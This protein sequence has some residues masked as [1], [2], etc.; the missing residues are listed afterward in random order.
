MLASI[1]LSLLAGIAVGALLLILGLRGKRINDHPTCR[2]CGFDLENV[3]PACITCP[4]C[5]SGL[6]RPKAVRPGQRR[7]RPVFIAAGLLLII[8]AIL[9]IG[10]AGFAAITGQD[11]NQYKPLGLLLW[12]AR[13]ADAKNGK[14]IAADLLTRM[15]SGKLTPAQEDRIT[16]L[17]LARQ[18]DPTVPWDDAW[19]DLIDRAKLDGRLSA[20]QQQ[21]FL[22]NLVVPRLKVRPHV[23]TGD[24]IPIGVES[25]IRGSPSMQNIVMIWL[26]D[27]RLNG[28][29]ISGSVPETQGA[30]PFMSW[31][32]A[33]SMP[34]TQIYAGGSKTRGFFSSSREPVVV[35]FTQPEDVNP[36]HSEVQIDLLVQAVPW[37]MN[38]PSSFMNTKPRATDPK[39]RLWKLR[40]PV[41]LVSNDVGAI[42]RVPSSNELS[43]KLAAHLRPNNVMV[44]GQRSDWMDG[45]MLT[46]T[47]Q[48]ADLPVPV[49]F[50]VFGRQGTHLEPLGSFTSGVGGSDNGFFG[51]QS[52]EGMRTL[53][54]NPRGIKGSNMD[55]VLKPRP[56]LAARTLDMTKVYDGEIVIE[57]V[58]IRTIGQAG[59][60]TSTTSTTVTTDSSD[61]AAKEDQP[62]T[63]D[64]PA[65]K[66]QAKS[67]SWLSKWVFFWN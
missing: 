44:Y 48:V 27:S 13:H 1:L 12:E 43:E 28:K 7:R 62:K 19:G 5:G 49:A 60:V 52:E 65:K 6:N 34:L 16:D 23:A 38:G 66:P 18:E 54:C 3:Y 30:F 45:R 50:D 40:V 46:M 20:D 58:A 31:A 29:P 21:R 42:T 24:P 9:P 39:A 15:L 26:E 17:A 64:P 56:N 36:A 2:D 61:D 37:N 53:S 33:P 47:F 4:E 67:K 10:A 41:E 35:S 11:I 22:R 63:E 25:E 14:A 51:Q 59:V 57:N 55:L 8:T 32:G